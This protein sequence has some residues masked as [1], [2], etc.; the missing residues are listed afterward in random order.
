MPEPTPR[1]PVLAMRRQLARVR[2]RKNL[3]ELQRALYALIA[4]AA[5][6]AGGG[7]LL[8][9]RAGAFG[10][11]LGAS[12]VSL[13]AL[14]AA[15]AVGV[16]TRRR[17]LG[18]RRAAG[19]IDARAGLKGRLATALELAPRGPEASFLPLLV[20][21]NVRRLR[22]WEPDRV[23]PDVFPYG[24][25]GVALVATSLF[26]VVLRAAPGLRPPR[27]AIESQAIVAA[28]L[29]PSAERGAVPV[30]AGDEREPGAPG[31][32]TRL[33]A[34]L[35]ERIRE[36]AWGREWQAAAAAH[37]QEMPSA[38]PSIP[39]DDDQL[40]RGWQI[41]RSTARA[42][43]HGPDGA[44]ADGE[45]GHDSSARGADPNRARREGATG[46]DPGPPAAGAGSGTDPNLYG[47]ATTDADAPGSFEL[48]L[49][50]RV[51]TVGGGP[52]PPSGEAPPAAADA[53]PG[54]AER[55]RRDSP[56]LRMAVP[57]SY[58]AIVRQLFARRTDEATP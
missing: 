44:A 32:V 2:W 14:G 28:R 21:Q 29:R 41:A 15:V 23:L 45:A 9:L 20:E 34:D 10:F 18:A 27:A 11:A 8:A 56:V 47:H 13:G 53:R 52:R 49:A 54:L 5:L 7:V 48:P 43:G 6:A 39:V 46:G 51:R 31:R 37:A 38:P 22:A 19:W 24:A 12:A 36:R 30:G 50:A 42:S 4:V 58:E 35:Q 26:L 1:D 40:E 55:P 3:Y 33:A 25:L 57:A 16:A 17:W